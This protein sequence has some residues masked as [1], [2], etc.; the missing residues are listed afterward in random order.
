M[1]FSGQFLL[2]DLLG[3]VFDHL[4]GLAG[5]AFDLIYGATRFQHK[6]DGAF[7]QAVKDQVLVF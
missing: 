1:A 2:V 3:V 6:D 5:Y 7:S 4:Q